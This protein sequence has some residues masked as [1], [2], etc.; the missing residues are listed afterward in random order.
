MNWPRAILF[1]LDGTLID[2]A[3]DLATSV[4]IVLA[5]EGLGPI[6]VEAVR[7]MIGNGIRK[8][9]QRAFAAYDVVLQPNELDL[10]EAAMIA[11]YNDNLSAET[12]LY[13][14]VPTALADVRARGIRMGVVT[15]KPIAATRAILSH[16]GILD[17]FG[18]VIGGDEN[19]PRKPA[20]DP[21]WAALQRMG[22][23]PE[24]SVM[25]GDSAADVAAARAAGS[26]VII[27][28]GGY[29]RVPVTELGADLTIASLSDLGDALR[30]WR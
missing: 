20:P 5:A 2:S 10:H 26:A 9:V 27:V 11:I 16:F 6:T 14:A 25:V 21:L 8:L 30:Q 4:N 19:I 18:A 22:A 28:E 13:P 23:T 29:S 12:I 17:I 7:D 1:D 3:P 24:Q 15:N